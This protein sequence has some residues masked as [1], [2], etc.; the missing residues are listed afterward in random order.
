MSVERQHVDFRLSPDGAFVAVAELDQETGGA[1]IHI[2]DLTRGDRSRVTS[3][4]TTDASPVWSPDG[5]QIVFRS[6]RESIHDLYIVDVASRTEK[7]FH[8]SRVA[9]Y[10]TSWSPE[11]VVAFHTNSDQTRWDVHVANAASSARSEVAATQFNEIQGQF[12][13]DGKL[14]A[15]TSDVDGEYQ[16][17]VKALPHGTPKTV[18]I[19]G[20][21][22]PRWSHDGRELFYIAGDD[23]LTAVEIQVR[24]DQV[25][26][27]RPKALFQVRDAARTA[28]FTSVYDVAPDGRFLIRFTRD[29]VR[30]IPLTVLLNWPLRARE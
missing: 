1:D 21:M 28:P 6:N 2:R 29:D 10:P 9:K 12:S 8:R 25:L 17:I 11:G 3:A 18:S 26:P 4:Q 22:D 14:F 20:G 5:K 27:G 24:G 7:P 15:Y 19:K 16:V 13:R 23:Q 30:S